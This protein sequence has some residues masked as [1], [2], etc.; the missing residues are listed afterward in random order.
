[1]EQRGADASDFGWQGFSHETTANRPDLS[2]S[3]EGF[4][5]FPI[6]IK[7]HDLGNLEFVNIAGFFFQ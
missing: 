2:G 4:D 5:L 6:K 7:I 3:A 1:L